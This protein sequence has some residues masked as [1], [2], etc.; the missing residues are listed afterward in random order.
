MPQW[1]VKDALGNLEHKY[2]TQYHAEQMARALNLNEG[3]H[4]KMYYGFERF[5][6]MQEQTA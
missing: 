2:F 6:V 4:F 5:T 3:T 1:I